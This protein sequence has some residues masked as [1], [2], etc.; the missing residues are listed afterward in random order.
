MR[1]LQRQP[2]TTVLMEVRRAAGLLAVYVA[3]P[4]FY[5]DIVDPLRA[6]GQEKG[7]FSFPR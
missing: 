3:I 1:D 6:V 7:R 5:G 4:T 2:Q